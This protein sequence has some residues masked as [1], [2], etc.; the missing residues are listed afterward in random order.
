VAPSEPLSA[1]SAILENDMAQAG[2]ER[3]V[4]QRKRRILASILSNKW[5]RSLFIDTVK[6]AATAFLLCVIL[7]SIF[8]PW[9]TPYDPYKG[10]IAERLQP[11]GS[12]KHWLGTDEQGRDL[13]TRLLYGGRITLLS[14][15]V[16]IS[17]ATAVGVTLGL[18]AGHFQG[19]VNTVIM[20]ILDIFYAFPAV[21]LAIG[22]SV[23]LGQGLT[24]SLVALS[25]VFMAPIA[26]VTETTVLKI[27]A[28]D[29]IESARASGAGH[30][31][32]MFKQ[33]L[34]N[35]IAP[36]LAYTTTLLGVSVILASGLSFLG[37]GITP[38][39][40][41]WGYMLNNLRNFIFNNAMIAI[42]PGIMIFLTAISFNLIGDAMDEA[43]TE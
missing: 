34:G 38:P 3:S 42:L 8:A 2:S 16:P 19:I 4:E 5:I 36:V 17:I 29:F 28:M 6:I 35:I 11:I 7:G 21:L 39:T 15:L 31:S 37:I 30:I 20:R 33:I 14:A 12:P 40:A 27:E 41:E 1:S 9:L 25:I 22:I 10:V 32:I 18:I 13:Y 23:A 24:S 43:R 26:R